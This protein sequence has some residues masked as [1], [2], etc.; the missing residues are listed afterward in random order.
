[1]LKCALCGPVSHNPVDFEIS[2][3]AMDRLL[4]VCRFCMEDLE[5]LGFHSN[6]VIRLTRAV[7]FEPTP[8]DWTA[9]LGPAASLLGHFERIREHFSVREVSACLL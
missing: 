5:L 6:Q 2:Y 4:Q 1:V 8:F 9:V 3:G 7:G